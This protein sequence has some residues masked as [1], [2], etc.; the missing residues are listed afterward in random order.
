MAVKKS[1]RWVSKVSTDSTP[2]AGAIQE[3]RR[4]N[5]ADPGVEGVPQKDFNHE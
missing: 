2:S 5:R 3:K 4:H 1:K